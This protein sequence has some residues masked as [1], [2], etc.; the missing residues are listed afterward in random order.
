MF[1]HYILS[2]IYYLLII[3]GKH[4]TLNLNMIIIDNA[5]NTMHFLSYYEDV[6]K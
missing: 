2:H 1:L 3:E 5:M 4:L 6:V